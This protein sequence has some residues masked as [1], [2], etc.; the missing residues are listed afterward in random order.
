MRGAGFSGA[1]QPV[2]KH[3]EQAVSNATKDFMA[4][5]NPTS[6]SMT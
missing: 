5:S 2:N 1:A 3:K 6:D 4:S